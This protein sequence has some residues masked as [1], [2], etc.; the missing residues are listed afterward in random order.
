MDPARAAV[1]EALRQ[2]IEGA[3]IPAPESLL[4]N[5]TPERA[6][7]KLDRSPY[8]ILTN[9]AHAGFWQEIWL[10]RIQGRRAR[11]FTEDWKTPEPSDWPTVRAQFLKGLEKA[12]EIAASEP[13]DHKMKSDAVAIRTLLQIAI[14]DA[15]HLGQVNLLKRELRLAGI[16]GKEKGPSGS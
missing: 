5:I 10:N 7:T 9:L 3:D 6:A 1:V 13:F 16:V 15:Y 2:V 8:S 14:H 12:I 11:S 4:R